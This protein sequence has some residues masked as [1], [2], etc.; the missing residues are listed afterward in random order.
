MDYFFW[1]GQDDFQLD[2]LSGVNYE[3]MV[4]TFELRR[5]LIDS[6][7]EDLWWLSLNGEVHD[8]TYDLS[9]ISE[10]ALDFPDQDLQV[11]HAVAT[12]A[13]EKSEWVKYEPDINARATNQIV[14]LNETHADSVEIKDAGRGKSPLSHACAFLASLAILMGW[15]LKQEHTL[16]LR[17]LQVEGLEKEIKLQK[18][19]ISSLDSQVGDLQDLQE[20]SDEAIGSRDVLLGRQNTQFEE[21]RASYL[22]LVDSNKKLRNQNS[23]LASDSAKRSAMIVALQNQINQ[24]SRQMEA[25]AALER[26]RIRLI[27]QQNQINQAIAEGVEAD[28]L[29]RNLNFLN[30]QLNK[31]KPVIPTFDP[32]QWELD[33]LNR[34]LDDAEFQRQ[35][36]EHNEA[37]RRN[38]EEA[39]RRW[40]QQKRDYENLPS[41]L[42]R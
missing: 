38:E 10:I 40:E 35:Q 13:D 19:Q 33:R 8:I 39:Q 37:V 42:D 23:E 7:E 5:W 34:R 22:A 24:D 6:S 12:S 1:R 41:I 4:K 31:A 30:A 20:A 28:R 29:I 18:N 27:G 25:I 2:A 32:T 15:I 36:R 21:L 26:E 3:D 14:V 17:E 9:E 11:Q 16:N